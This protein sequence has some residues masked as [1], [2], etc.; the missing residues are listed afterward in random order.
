VYQ[1]LALDLDGTLVRRDGQIDE[2]D[3]QAVAR[4]QASGVAV[5]IVT[6]RLYAGSRKVAREL[7]IQVPIG[8]ADGADI[9]D[10]RTDET[11]LHRGIVGP[12]AQA[13]RN[14]LQGLQL[15]VFPMCTK[16]VIH[17][18]IGEPFVRFIRNWSP[19]FEQVPDV[20][21]HQC[22]QSESGI[23]A[24]VAVGPTEAI[25]KAATALRH[26]AAFEVAD[27][28]VSRAPGVP[29]TARLHAL[30]A[31]AAG[32]SKGDAL[33]RIAGFCGCRADQTVAV[34]DW[35][36]DISLL[37]AAGRSFAMGHAPESVKHSATDQLQAD[38]KSG[39]GV[40]E[41]IAA[42]WPEV[43]DGPGS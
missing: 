14:A 5:T 25:G 12:A 13:M 10:P 29:P 2:R 24:L 27:F 7:N 26:T 43:L 21:A 16:V 39:G 19:D 30:L 11:L 23:T 15:A 8:C 22:W 9:V 38:G 41:A 42:A 6:G 36:N 18:E 35:L 33:R 32:V 34:G 4:L 28:A 31:H 37:A 1:L 40:A 17:D 20:L 3:R